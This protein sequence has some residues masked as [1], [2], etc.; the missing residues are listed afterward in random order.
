MSCPSIILKGL[1]ATHKTSHKDI[2][3]CDGNWKPQ[4]SDEATQHS[5]YL[6]KLKKI[7]Q[8]KELTYDWLK[9]KQTAAEDLNLCN[10]LFNSILLL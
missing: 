2:L 6:N 4:T 9:L 3:S 7:V 1:N 10:V 8:N 5:K